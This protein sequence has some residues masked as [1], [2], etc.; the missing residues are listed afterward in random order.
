M[1]EKSFR[2]GA[3]SDAKL[4]GW[5]AWLECLAGRIYIHHLYVQYLLQRDG[6][7]QKGRLGQLPWSCWHAALGVITQTQSSVWFSFHSN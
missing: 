6:V 1:K 5:S 2:I 7:Q 4:P 3:E